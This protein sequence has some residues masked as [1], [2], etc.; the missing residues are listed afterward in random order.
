[1]ISYRRTHVSMS[2]REV[3]DSE[4][5]IWAFERVTGNTHAH[6]KAKHDYAIAGWILFPDY[7]G[8]K[9]SVYI[10][11]EKGNRY[12]KIGF[13]KS[14]DIYEFL[15]GTGRD[16][17]SARKCRFHTGWDAE[18]STENT[19]WYLGLYEKDQADGAKVG[20]S[21]SERTDLS[22]KERSNLMG[23]WTSTIA[24]RIVNVWKIL[25]LCQYS[26]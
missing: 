14:G 21:R 6:L 25:P 11:D 4:E 18:D 22:A 12:K 19:V 13:K 17:K 5:C 16:L 8:Q 23:L 2:A 15:K 20:E 26:V 24:K 3:P 1:M 7:D 10:E 9:M